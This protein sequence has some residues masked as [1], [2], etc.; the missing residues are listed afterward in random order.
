MKK[1]TT[2]L[3]PLLA[4]TLIFSSCGSNSHAT[5]N[6][7]GI[8]SATLSNATASTFAFQ[9]TLTVNADGSLGTTSFSLTLNNTPCSF[10]A[11]TE[12]GS[13]TISG[14]FNGQVSGA[15]HYVITS[16]GAESSVLTLNGTVSAGQITGTWSVTGGTESCTGNGTFTMNPVLAP[17]IRAVPPRSQAPVQ[18]SFSE[19]STPPTSPLTSIDGPARIS[20]FS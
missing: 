1:I 18:D 2:V 7:N 20:L 14:N 4:M 13:F 8:W 9:T 5:G 15:F 17:D 11:T 10:P 12:S 6:I 19:S 3:V 16:T